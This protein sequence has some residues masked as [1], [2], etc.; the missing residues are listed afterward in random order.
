MASTFGSRLQ[1][2]REE[3]GLT[4]AQLAAEIGK[5]RVTVSNWERGETSPDE[6]DAE[7]VATR[8]GT[9]VRSLRYGGD[10]GTSFAAPEA[11]RRIADALSPERASVE[12]PL[13]RVARSHAV[14]VWQKEFEL[15]LVKAGATEDQ[16][17]EA[18]D[19]VRAPQVF[20]FFAGGSPKGL[21]EQEAIEG[22]E[23]LATLVRTQ[24]RQRH[25]LKFHGKPQA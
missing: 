13:P 17:A 4:Q 3:A 25:G 10:E 14:R 2:L 8:L 20:T 11:A 12:R 15:E 23:A 19:L 18:M 6:A 24:Y 1:A 21:T 7:L 9:T 22:M 16:V 5:S